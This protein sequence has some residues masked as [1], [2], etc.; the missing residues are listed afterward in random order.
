MR[1]AH[2]AR[3]IAI[4]LYFLAPIPHPK[5]TSKFALDYIYHLMLEHVSSDVPDG[6]NSGGVLHVASRQSP[7]QPSTQTDLNYTTGWSMPSCSNQPAQKLHDSRL[8]HYSNRHTA[9]AIQS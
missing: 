7:H 3:A 2:G 5:P 4:G 1:N 6:G 8:Q 9:G